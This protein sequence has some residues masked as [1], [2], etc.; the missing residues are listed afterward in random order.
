[1]RIVHPR[2][3]PAKVTGRFQHHILRCRMRTHNRKSPKKTAGRTTRSI[4]LP[5]CKQTLR[6]SSTLLV[7]SSLIIILYFAV[8]LPRRRR[9]N[10]TRNPRAYQSRRVSFT[11][12][13][14]LRS[15][16]RFRLRTI[17]WVLI[18]TSTQ[19]CVPSYLRIV[20][21]IMPSEDQSLLHRSM[22]YCS[23][24]VSQ[25]PARHRSNS[26]QRVGSKLK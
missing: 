11:V 14:T 18:L 10:N 23:R 5:R 21:A 6:R 2:G 3:Y 24:A 19:R 13:R 20:L 25:S 26:C 12:T 22:I 16:S 9:N 4:K 15:H 8:L 1:M 7:R 17:P